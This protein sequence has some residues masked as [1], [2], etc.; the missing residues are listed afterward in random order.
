VG[1]YR[2]VFKIVQR[3]VW[4]LGIGPSWKPKHRMHKNTSRV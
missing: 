1:D 3:D 4:I 2:V